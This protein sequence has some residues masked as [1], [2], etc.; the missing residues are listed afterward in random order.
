[1]ARTYEES[2]H[3]IATAS[4]AK[5]TS[6]YRREEEKYTRCSSSIHFV[7]TCQKFGLRP[8]FVSY[9]INSNSPSLK[10]RLAT[11]LQ[12]KW[13]DAVRRSLH[14]KNA[15]S[16]DLIKRA[17][18][19][20]HTLMP[21]QDVVEL[22]T[23]SANR[24]KRL[25][26]LL[27]QTKL[28]K[29]KKLVEE[30]FRSSKPVPK[31][32]FA[33]PLI[34]LTSTTFT[35]KELE[36]LNK[37][38]KLAI[39]PVNKRNTFEA[40]VLA[41]LA[42]GLRGDAR[43]NCQRTVKL[44]EKMTSQMS[45]ATIPQSCYIFRSLQ[46]KLKKED[47][48]I[49]KADKGETLI[50]LSRKTYD[51]KIQT[52][53][54]NSRA[55]CIPYSL[56][57][58]NATIR[59]AVNNSKHVFQ[60]KRDHLLQMCPSTPRL[61]GQIKLHKQD[62]PIRPVVAFYTDPSYYVA[63]Y[64]VTWYINFADHISPYGLKNSIELAEL[65]H[66]QHFP[67][68]ARLISFDVKSMYTQIPVLK[69]IDIMSQHLKQIGNPDPVIA[70]F[71][72]IITKCLKDNICSFKGK[73][74][75]FPDGLPMG[76]PLSSLTAEV[77]MSKLESDI[78]SSSNHSNRIHFWRRY[79]DD[80]ICVWNGTDVQ[81]QHFLDELNHYHPSIEFTIEIGGRVINY[82]DLTIQLVS[83][84][85]GLTPSLDIYR[86]N[87]FSGISIHAHSLHPPHHKMS[88][89]LAAIHRLLSLPLSKTAIETETAQIEKI[90]FLNGLKIDVRRTIRKKRL[91]KL[92]NYSRQ[93]T[94]TSSRR[95]KWIRLPYV[96]QTSNQLARELKR[97][98]YKVGFYPLTTLGSLSML[99]DPIPQM[100]KPGVYKVSCGE[101]PA[102]YVGQTGRPLKERFK[103][104][105]SAAY[106][107]NPERSA[108]ALHCAAYGHDPEK[109]T[110]NHIH[111][112][113][114]GKT[115]NRLEEVEILAANKKDEKNLLN[116]LQDTTTNP[117]VQFVINSS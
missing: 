6:F 36:L 13:L 48:V 23:T 117:I 52:F 81:L 26:S 90:V 24:Q 9:R 107:N 88:A 69:S 54:S 85:H 27:H 47:L 115:L 103:E 42:C 86:K 78:I 80:V 106:S 21:H 95:Q 84:T 92:L 114:K 93:P 102:I 58:Y 87:T 109:L 1:M 64:L 46:Q 61:Y 41:D 49:C 14:A 73:T 101:C 15:M 29:L 18:D 38:R 91:Q 76:G 111:I 104:H 5:L 43:L 77:F 50:I 55:T 94:Q 98:D 113:N 3:L 74:Y 8:S 116:D 4:T 67:S 33:P 2:I 89:V 60:G 16:A 108:V 63:K 35:E 20:L 75:K 112:C 45:K 51:E 70:E 105:I 59:S 44:L 30:K 32:D 65:L 68:S 83:S 96:G 17:Q 97:L 56:K 7:T 100:D 12:Q 11:S 82:L 110:A 79:V 25:K 22:I 66:G 28:A 10:N 39:L 57:A 53:L 40:T 72:D 99:K 34:N 37:G 31:P 71:Q 19:R 62:H